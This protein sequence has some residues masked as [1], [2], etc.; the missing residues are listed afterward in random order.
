[1]RLAAGLGLGDSRCSLCIGHS[2]AVNVTCEVPDLSS[3]Q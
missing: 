3:G 2:R 1:M